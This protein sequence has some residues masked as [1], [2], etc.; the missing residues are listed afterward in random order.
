VLV[1]Y[2]YASRGS[3]QSYGDLIRHHFGKK[4]AAL[5][6]LAI[7]VH[8]GKFGDTFPAVG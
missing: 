1:W 8:V 6:Q 7:C 4:G 5:L 2:S 3:F